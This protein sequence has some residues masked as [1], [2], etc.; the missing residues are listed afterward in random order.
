MK[1]ETVREL[2]SVILDRPVSRLTEKDCLAALS[3][4]RQS[5]G[6]ELTDEVKA[7]VDHW[8][9]CGDYDVDD[10]ITKV[11]KTYADK[12]HSAGAGFVAEDFDHRFDYTNR[13]DEVTC[14]LCKYYTKVRKDHES[15]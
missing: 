5:K 9:E 10:E 12:M 11:S 6:L 14:P 1:T 8:I 4:V 15:K 3:L 13:E 7:L 2:L